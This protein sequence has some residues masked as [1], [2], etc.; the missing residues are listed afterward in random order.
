MAVKKRKSKPK[1]HKVKQ[2]Q[3]QKQNIVIS[4]N[5]SKPVAKNTSTTSQ[6]P[7]TVYQASPPQVVYI[8]QLAPYPQTLLSSAP[9][10]ANTLGNSI[11]KPNYPETVKLP[12]GRGLF[13]GA[14]PKRLGD[15]IDPYTLNK[16]DNINADF[17]NVPSNTPMADLLLDNRP[18]DAFAL[19][20]KVRK[21]RAPLEVM[22]DL[23]SELSVILTQKGYSN[24]EINKI[25][26]GKGE[27]KLRDLITNENIKI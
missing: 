5:N 11:A 2:H 9:P 3:H 18:E 15:N 12:E 7:T 16:P 22:N 4:I 14:E 23:R 21:A 17:D 19:A 26:K 1:H 27:N 6:K 13:L 24:E 25:L 10:I 8:P 20:D